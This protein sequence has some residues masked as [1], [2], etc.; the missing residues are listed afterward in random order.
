MLAQGVRTKTVKRAARVIIEKYYPRMTL[1]FQTNKR[2]C[3]EVAMIPTKALKNKIAG[4]ATVSFCTR[5]VN[6]LSPGA[7]ASLLLR[8]RAHHIVRP[9]RLFGPLRLDARRARLSTDRVP[10]P[11]AFRDRST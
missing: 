8:C 4:Y 10:C 6:L 1:D 5:P 2:V 3:E 7:G 9:L 11:S